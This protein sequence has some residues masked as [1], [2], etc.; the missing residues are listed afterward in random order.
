MDGWMQDGRNNQ[1]MDDWLDGWL[2]ERW[3]DGWM[4][5][6]KKLKLW[7]ILYANVFYEDG[8]YVSKKK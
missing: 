7:I 8:R 1:G 4:E 6:Y 5:C 3:M 2:D